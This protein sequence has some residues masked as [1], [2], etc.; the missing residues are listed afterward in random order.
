[1]VRLGH[2]RSVDLA[3]MECRDA[4]CLPQRRPQRGLELGIV[5]IIITEVPR[6]SFRETISCIA[7]S[8]VATCHCLALSY[9]TSKMFLLLLL[10]LSSCLSPG[11]LR[12]YLL[13]CHSFCGIRPG[14]SLCI[15]LLLSHT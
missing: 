3:C 2:G 13:R 11:L 4:V 5:I 14:L 12:G 10:L 7:T 1:M 9:G 8:L 15:F 6:L